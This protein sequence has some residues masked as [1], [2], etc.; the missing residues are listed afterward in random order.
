MSAGTLT[1][2]WTENFIAKGLDKTFNYAWDTF[3][4]GKSISEVEQSSSDWTE[5]LLVCPSLHIT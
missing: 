5:S 1:L 4:W 2:R 3:I